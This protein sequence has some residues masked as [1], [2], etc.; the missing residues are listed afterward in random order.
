MVFLLDIE[1]MNHSTS[2]EWGKGGRQGRVTTGSKDEKNDTGDAA[3]VPGAFGNTVCRAGPIWRCRTAFSD[4]VARGVATMAQDCDL[5]N[6][7]VTV[8]VEDESN[9]RVAPT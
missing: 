6:A 7:A 2:T 8:P 4:S 9:W 3:T 5:T 1:S